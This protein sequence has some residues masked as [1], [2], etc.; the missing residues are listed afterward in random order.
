MKKLC[1]CYHGTNAENAESI[2]REGFRAW[3]YFARHLEDAVGYGGVNIFEVSFITD[4]VPNN[5][6][7]RI[8]RKV[9]ASKIVRHYVFNKTI[10]SENSKL[11]DRIFKSNIEDTP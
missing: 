10:I 3:T 9:N 1:I 2:K 8:R 5:W 7:F 6:Q 11:L 4:K